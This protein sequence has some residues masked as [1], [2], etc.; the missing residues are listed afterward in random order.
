MEKVRIGVIGCSEI[1]HAHAGAVAAADGSELVAAA[2]LDVSTADALAAEHSGAKAYASHGELLAN[3]DVDAVVICVPTCVHRD[4]AIDA[5]KAGKHV[6]LE[7]PPARNVGEL[8]EIADAAREADRSLM[9]CYQR[10]HDPVHRRAREMIREGALGKVYYGRVRWFTC[11]SYPLRQ[12]H[13]WRWSTRGGAMASLGSH[14]LDLQLWL[15]DYPEWEQ[16]TAWAH[17]DIAAKTVDVG[18]DAG[19]DLMV[20]LIRLDNGV[21]IKAEA[22]RRIHGPIGSGCELYGEAA[23]YVETGKVVRRLSR[24]EQVE[25]PVGDGSATKHRQTRAQ[26]E[27]FIDVIRGNA[28][29][30][31]GIDQALEMQSLLDAIYESAETGNAVSRPAGEIPRLRSE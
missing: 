11:H 1:G 6:L 17:R 22:S 13:C 8:R 30:D 28:E 9:V 29:P 21:A 31:M 19:D 7:K 20:A 23:S 18:D 12:E 10:R 26:M 24:T 16:V 2:D 15:M 5:F 27:H 4:V 14:L 25:E 3:D